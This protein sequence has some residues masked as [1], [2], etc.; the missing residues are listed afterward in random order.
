MRQPQSVPRS[1]PRPVPLPPLRLQTSP[2][3]LESTSP[4][5]LKMPSAPA[6]P[7]RSPPPGPHPPRRR[8]ANPP[9]PS[10]TPHIS[11]A[12]KPGTGLTLRIAPTDQVARLCACCHP[13][14][15]PRHRRKHSHIQRGQCNPLRHPAGVDHPERVCGSEHTLYTVHSRLSFRFSAGPMSRRGMKVGLCG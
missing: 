9:G 15:F 8:G 13:H 4:C 10:R 14:P 12:G 7:R 1:P 5:T 6:C 3:E 11:L 2:A